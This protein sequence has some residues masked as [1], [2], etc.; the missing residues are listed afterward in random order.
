MIQQ[1]VGNYRVIRQVGEGGM[2]IIFEAIHE[3]MGRRAA[4]KVLHP[5]LSWNEELARRFLNEARAVNIVRHPGIVDVFEFGK[6]PD[7]TAYIV[8]EYLEGES[9]DVRL[10]KSE[11]RTV[12]D[13]LRLGRQIAAALSAA[14]ERGIIHRD[15]K[16][17]NL[18]IIADPEQPGGERIKLLDFGIAKLSSADNPG[19][20]RTRTGMVMGTPLYMA[21][22][23]CR[24]LGQV[25][26]KADVYALGVIFYQFLGGQPPFTAEGPGEVM[27]MHMFAEPAPLGGVNSS[28]PPDLLQ[29]VHAMLAKEPMERPS[30][31][32]VVGAIDHLVGAIAATPLPC[33][34]QR[35]FSVPEPQSRGLSS[36]LGQ[37]AAQS[38]APRSAAAAG[39]RRWLLWAGLAL[40]VLIWRT[41]STEVAPSVLPPNLTVSPPASPLPK[42][43][44][45]PALAARVR[46]SVDSEPSGAQVVEAEGG[47][48]LGVAPWQIERPASVGS[49]ALLL[50][51][52][53]FAARRIELPAGADATRREI[54]ARAPAPTLTPPRTRRRVGVD[55]SP[56]EDNLTD[57]K[58][59]MLK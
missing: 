22:E 35:A 52:P 18:M 34:A 32:Q 10:H 46:W 54:L 1:R 13:V 59:Q 43:M 50:R 57:E 20:L 31:S 6:L 58:I 11:G 36:T 26:A 24:G 2:G 17:E 28:L 16:P 4:V 12:L 37:A 5:H 49:V 7:G 45:S 19:H 40:A 38:G 30:M 41:K 14:H 25:D 23:Q 51:H 53:G 9:L 3:Q 39:P 56:S 8:M 44:A 42:L 21:P 15:L 48:V 33:Q 29:L 55:P 27:A 47:Q